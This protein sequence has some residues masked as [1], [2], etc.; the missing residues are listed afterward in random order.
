MFKG[1]ATLEATRSFLDRNQVHP[2]QRRDFCNMQ[3]SSLAVGT[4]LG[5]MD[6][7]TDAKVAAACVQSFKMGCNF[8]DSAINYRGQRAERSVGEAIKQGI[9]SKVIMREEIFVS[10]KGGFIP[11]E[12]APTRDVSALF[13]DQYVSRGIAKD[14]D[15]IAGCHCLDPSYLLDQIERS[16][17]NLGLETIDL[18]Y[19]HNPEIQLEEIPERIFY[20][21]LLDAFVALEKA[22]VAGKIA[23]YGMATW[24]AFREDPK[25]QT[26]VQLEK[27]VEAAAQAAEIAETSEHHFRAIQLPFNLAMPEA[28]LVKTQKFGTSMISPIEAAQAFDLNVAVSVPL[29]QARLCHNLPDFIVENFPKEFSQAYCALAFASSYPGVDSA[30][31]GMKQAQHVEHNLA[32]LKQPTLTEQQIHKIVQSMLA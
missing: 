3:V 7:V 24:G 19:L 2:S 29:F 21:K 10:T 6:E 1:K 27:C 32:F 26:S 15:L 9:L 20:A 31:V 16:R 14:A 13:R 8:V 11:Y 23:A 28:A 25:A 5:H 22:V 17:K 12:G 18:F 4:Y 30:M